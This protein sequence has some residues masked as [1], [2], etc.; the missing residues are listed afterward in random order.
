LPSNAQDLLF[1]F[2][3]A[4][5]MLLVLDNFEHLRDGASL[6]EELQNQA[7]GVKLLVTSRQ[8]LD[9]ASEVV[10]ELHGLSTP[11]MQEGEHIQHHASVQLFLARARRVQPD[12][13]LDIENSTSIAIS[14]GCRRHAVGPNWQP[15]DRQSLQEIAQSKIFDL[16]ITSPACPNGTQPAAILILNHL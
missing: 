2:L 6:L 12:F 3:R 9:L 4:K 13:N 11:T 7:N 5:E 10:F 14:A 16:L 15:P 1:S 8:R